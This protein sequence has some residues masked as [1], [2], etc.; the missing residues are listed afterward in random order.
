V[1]TL[2]YILQIYCEPN[3]QQKY[4]YRSIGGE[5][6]EDVKKRVFDFINEIRLNQKNKKILVV[7]YGGVIRLL[8][9]VLHNQLPE[10]IH[11]ASVHEFEFPDTI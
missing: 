2:K 4:D 6:F 7:T 10:T 1:T 8:H 11:N 9:Y 5:S 3:K